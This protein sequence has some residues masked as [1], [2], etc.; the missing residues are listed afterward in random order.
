LTTNHILRKRR[1]VTALTMMSREDDEL[2][3]L[4]HPVNHNARLLLFLNSSR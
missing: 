2:H 1:I 3:H 4:K